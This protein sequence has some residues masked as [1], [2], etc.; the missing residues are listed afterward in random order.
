MARSPYADDSDWDSRGDP[1][2]IGTERLPWLETDDDRDYEPGLPTGRL[3]TM[4]LVALAV[5]VALV[6]AIWW[7]SGRTAGEPPADGSIIAAPEEPYKTRPAEKGGKT[8][9]GTGDTSFAVGEGQVREG[10]LAERAPAPAIAT[11]IADAEPP[12]TPAQRT[13]ERAEAA[14][15]QPVATASEAAPAPAPA[16][17][18]TA[19]QV[20]AFPDRA[21]AEDAWQRLTRQTEALAGVRHRVVEARVDIGR[22]YR[23]QALA[24]DRASARRLCDALKA[25]GLACFIK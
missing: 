21:A 9:A 15:A 23:L 3:V 14:P 25:D 1:D 6:G 17:S 10:R 7:L 5:L 19:V 24:G 16:A 4:G 18:G 11:D 8:F 12:A 20:G 2:L 22:V 13:S